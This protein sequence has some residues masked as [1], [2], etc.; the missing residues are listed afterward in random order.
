MLRAPGDGS[1]TLPESTEE[2]QTGDTVATKKSESMLGRWDA[3]YGDTPSVPRY[4]GSA[5]TYELVADFLR[6]MAVEDWGCG[7]AA[8]A[9]HHEGR[10][11]G[12][13]GTASQYVDTIA[14]L[15]AFRSASPAILLR[16]VLEHN[17]DWRLV[18]DNAIASTT[19]RLAIVLF[20]PLA[21]ETT[22]VHEDVGGLGV[23][24]I[25]FALDD[26]T[27]PI[28]DAGFS[29]TVQSVETGMGYTETLISC[30][31]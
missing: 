28:T 4:Y 7:L 16:H 18:L 20:M 14:D 24:D 6:G 8:Y 27:Q 5:D 12:V 13:D 23:P 19:E 2:R 9:D 31:R 10:Y 26:I 11:T 1:S 30:T 22:V 15:T 21:E 25:S 29:V 17:Y 3:W